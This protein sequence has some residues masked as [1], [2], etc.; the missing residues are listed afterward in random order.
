M[1]PNALVF[2]AILALNS[3]TPIG[4]AS[5]PKSLK[6]RLTVATASALSISR[7]QLGHHIGRCGCRGPDTENRVGLHPFD[8]HFLLL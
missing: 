6:R 2:S 1:L 5:P 4:V 3:A 7:L 8:A